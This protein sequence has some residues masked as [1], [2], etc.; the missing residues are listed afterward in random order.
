MKRGQHDYRTAKNIDS[1][2][3]MTQRHNKKNDD[4]YKTWN[5]GW[6]ELDAHN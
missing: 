5:R 4:K 3:S 6:N 1:L 2:L